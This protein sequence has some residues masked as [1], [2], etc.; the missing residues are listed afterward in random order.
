MA[1][2]VPPVRG[3]GC[4][5]WC[6]SRRWSPNAS[7]AS[8]V[9]VVHGSRQVS[10]PVHAGLAYAGQRG[11]AA[12]R[13]WAEGGRTGRD[14]A[15][16]LGMSAA[17]APGEQELLTLTDV[18][19]TYPGSPPV[20]ALRDVTFSVLAGEVLGIIGR[21]GSGKSTLLNVLGLLDL[22]TSGDYRVEGERVGV[23][24]RPRADNAA[25]PVLRV[26]VPGVVPAAVAERAGERRARVAAASADARRAARTRDRRARVR[27][28]CRTGGGFCRAR[29]PAASASGWR[30]RGRSRNDRGCCCV[31]SRPATSTSAPA[32]RCCRR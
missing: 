18:G 7:G 16:W 4:N 22:P 12:D 8:S 28:G 23:V 26:R 13:R 6:R 3:A 30:S 11:R 21:S 32:A 2:H 20:H 9:T 25:G 1:L 31:T 17:P 24:E 15:R 19:R 27:S 14:R 29:C 5:G 10:V